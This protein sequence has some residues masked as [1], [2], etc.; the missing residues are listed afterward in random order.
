MSQKFSLYEDL[1]VWENIRLFAGIYGMAEDEIARK[2]DELLERIGLSAERDTLVKSLPLGWKQ[3]LAFSVS[4]FH[5]PKIAAC[6]E[7]MAT[8]TRNLSPRMFVRV[9]S[10]ATGLSLLQDI[11]AAA[12]T[13]NAKYFNFML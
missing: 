1:K 5:E 2:T 4:I 11:N 10:A 8:P 13:D 6:S 12:Q 7:L 9:G 3:K